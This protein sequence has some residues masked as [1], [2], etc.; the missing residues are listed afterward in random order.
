MVRLVLLLI[1]KQDEEEHKYGHF[2]WARIN[3]MPIFSKSFV[4]NV[5]KMFNFNFVGLEPYCT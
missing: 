5:N 3:K 1:I 2:K 4:R